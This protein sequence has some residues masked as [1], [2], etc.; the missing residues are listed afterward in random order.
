MILSLFLGMPSLS[1]DDID[2]STNEQPHF[3]SA[4]GGYGQNKERV[5]SEIVE[6]QLACVPEQLQAEIRQGTEFLTE[7]CVE[8]FNIIYKPKSLSTKKNQKSA[9]QEAQRTYSQITSPKPPHQNRTPSPMEGR[10][11]MRNPSPPENQPIRK[12]SPRPAAHVSSAHDADRH[13]R[14]SPAPRLYRSTSESSM[15]PRRR[16]SSRDYS[17]VPY[18]RRH[19]PDRR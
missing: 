7:D 3:T 1:A 5:Y 8:Q 10:K 12:R 18:R 6:A 13:R 15:P 9:Q 4:L 19:S 11:R 16:S 14:R 17:P 2:Y